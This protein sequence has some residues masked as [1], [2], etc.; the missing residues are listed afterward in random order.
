M[1]SLPKIILGS[2]THFHLGSEGDSRYAG[3][4]AGPML[5]DPWA[6]TPDAREL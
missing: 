3:Y 2:L 1:G 4:A 6:L 5:A